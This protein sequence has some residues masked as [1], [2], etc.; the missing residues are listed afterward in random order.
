MTTGLAGILAYESHWYLVNKVVNRERIGSK[1][2]KLVPSVSI[3]NSDFV[4]LLV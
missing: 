3:D 4:K 1:A 2:A